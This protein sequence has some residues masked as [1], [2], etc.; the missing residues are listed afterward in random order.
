[1]QIILYCSFSRYEI[2]TLQSERVNQC[3]ELQGIFFQ[4][5]W[6]N[7]LG[8]LQE[9]YILFSNKI[10]WRDN[11]HILELHF[12]QCAFLDRGSSQTLK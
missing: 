1:M 9:K 4:V 6:V 10:L 7:S 12:E 2:Y 3:C 11:L 8:L 5:Y